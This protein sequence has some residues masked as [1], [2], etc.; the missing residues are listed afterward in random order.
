MTTHSCWLSQLLLRLL[1]V[2]TNTART[3]TAFAWADRYGYMRCWVRT[4]STVEA[5]AAEKENSLIE[6]RESDHACGD[7]QVFKCCPQSSNFPSEGPCLKIT[8]VGV[9][10]GLPASHCLPQQPKVLRVSLQWLTNLMK[11][12]FRD[13]LD[14]SFRRECWFRSFL[15]WDVSICCDRPE[16]LISQCKWGCWFLANLYSLALRISKSSWSPLSEPVRF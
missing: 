3:R 5:R 1:L 7:V 11:P 8:G 4:G 14:W 16:P 9:S 13:H 15:H 10:W 2:L 12:Y 6:V